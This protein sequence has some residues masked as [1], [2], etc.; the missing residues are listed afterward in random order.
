MRAD[1]AGPGRCYASDEQIAVNGFAVETIH[2]RFGPMLRWGPLV[3][4]GG[5]AGSYGAGALSGDGTDAILLELGHE[6]DE[7]AAWREA[8]VVG[9]ETV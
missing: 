5:P 2:A 3:T 7:I 4:V 6:Q 1:G 8:G 9:S